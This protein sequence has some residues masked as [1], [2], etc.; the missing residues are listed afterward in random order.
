MQL[1]PNNYSIE[2]NGLQLKLILLGLL[3]FSSFYSAVLYA[4]MCVSTFSPIDT[5]IH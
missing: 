1:R 2:K 4:M 3:N 5:K